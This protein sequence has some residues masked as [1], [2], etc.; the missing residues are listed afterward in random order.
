MVV[1]GSSCSEWVC[2]QLKAG[3]ISGRSEWG[4]NDPVKE[5]P[6]LLNY[7]LY[8]PNFHTSLIFFK[9]IFYF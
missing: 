7:S 6:L 1:R 2:M 4:V 9:I 5:C 3:R 8:L